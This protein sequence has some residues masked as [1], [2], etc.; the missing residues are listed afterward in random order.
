MRDS[1]QDAATADQL[2]LQRQEQEV[3]DTRLSVRE[4]K[5]TRSEGLHKVGVNQ[6]YQRE[7]L[8]QL[9]HLAEVRRARRRA[10]RQGKLCVDYQSAEEAAA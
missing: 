7:P 10:D 5:E 4:A 9:A 6:L 1:L 2:V 8:R 3:A